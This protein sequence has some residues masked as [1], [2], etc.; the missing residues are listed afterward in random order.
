MVSVIQETRQ[1][2]GVT[3]GELARRLG[4]STPA[5]SQWEKSEDNGT[6]S[7]NTLRKALAALGQQ[8]AI[9]PTPNAPWLPIRW[10]NTDLVDSLQP[11]PSGPHKTILDARH[12][13]R[14]AIIAGECVA[15]G[16][17]LTADQ[18]WL[19]TDHI[20]VATP[21]WCYQAAAA[22][23]DSY[24]QLLQH[25]QAGLYMPILHT[26]TGR[27]FL[28]PPDPTSL[29]D[30]LDW[31]FTAITNAVPWLDALRA[32]AALSTKL[33]YNWPLLPT[34][35]SF[36]GQWARAVGELTST[37]AADTLAVL[38]ITAMERRLR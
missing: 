35:P 7:L 2:Q 25:V 11:D 10:W 17:P 27:R 33:G 22:V 14:Q 37:G 5:V 9:R 38:V 16:L 34:R 32:V 18:L 31:G 6:I 19:I 23:R 4:V 20:T 21:L 8:A 36:A 28:P 12:G 1:A 26:S 15:L 29:R 3:Q 30:V 13:D 24:D